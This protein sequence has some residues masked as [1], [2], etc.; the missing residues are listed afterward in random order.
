[1]RPHFNRPANPID[2]FLTFREV[3][4]QAAL[5]RVKPDNHYRTK[6]ETKISHLARSQAESSAK[7]KSLENKLRYH[8]VNPARAL[9]LWWEHLTG[10]TRQ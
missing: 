8:A 10:K 6:A 2:D 4:L 3:E 7:I 9:K 1:M 5:N